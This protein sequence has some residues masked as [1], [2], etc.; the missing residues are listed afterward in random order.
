MLAG[1]RWWGLAERRRVLI[2]TL[3]AFWSDRMCWRVM[4]SAS[5]RW[6][7]PSTHWHFALRRRTSGSSPWSILAL[8]I[9]RAAHALSHTHAQ[10]SALKRSS[11]DSESCTNSLSRTHACTNVH[12]SL[13]RA[14]SSSQAVANTPDAQQRAGKF[15]RFR[16]AHPSAQMLELVCLCVC[17]VFTPA[18]KSNSLIHRA[19]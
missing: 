15:S 1:R 14:S 4:K 9:V 17:F 10:T 19:I 12:R 18:L 7:E 8:G 11:S 16:S 6:H 13:S 2:T 5:R 3:V